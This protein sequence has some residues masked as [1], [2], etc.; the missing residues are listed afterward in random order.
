[1]KDEIV[2]DQQANRVAWLVGFIEGDGS[3]YLDKTINKRNRWK[4]TPNMTI[5]NMDYDLICK[6]EKILKE[7]NIPYFI[8]IRQVKNGI[9]YLLKIRGYKRMKKFIDL[10]DGMFCGKNELKLILI[11]DLV[12]LRLSNLNG[13][14]NSEMDNTEKA[15][16]MKY[17]ELRRQISKGKKHLKA[18]TSRG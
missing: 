7:N 3:L 9:C 18:P 12:N 5:T 11:K 4:V 8:S 10:V 17:D 6:S 16:Y 13:N 1:M 14:C 2:E 15:I